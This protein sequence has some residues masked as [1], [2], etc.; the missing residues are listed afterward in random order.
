MRSTGVLL[1]WALPLAACAGLSAAAQKIH[2]SNKTETAPCRFLKVVYGGPSLS[3]KNEALE[4]AA[5]AHA[6]H[7]VPL[8]DQNEKFTADAFDCDQSTAP[9]QIAAEKKDP[10]PSASMSKPPPRPDAPQQ[11]RWVIAVM[12]VEDRAQSNDGVSVVL[13]RNIGDQL[14]IF[15]AERGLRTIDRGEQEKA[16][17]QQITEAKGDSY[18]SCYDNSCQIELGKA[19][20]ASHILRA[21]VARFGKSCVLNAELIDLRAE[22]T[23]AATSSRGACEEEGFLSMS[24]KVAQTLVADPSANDQ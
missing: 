15:I 19:L 11:G 6:T 18:K 13:L 4:N 14:R 5:S 20:A 2:V 3:A 24:E 7:I 12:D 10:K 16:R 8:Y 21:Q 1:L 9:V 22:V 23:I 17:H